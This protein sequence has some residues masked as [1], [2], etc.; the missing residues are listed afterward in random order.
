MQNHSYFCINLTAP[1]ALPGL[2]GH[3]VLDYGVL[4]GHVSITTSAGLSLNS[5]KSLSQPRIGQ[6]KEMEMV[7]PD[8]AHA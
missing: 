5:S 4:N 3:R 8:W 7:Y 6:A 2:D 1:D